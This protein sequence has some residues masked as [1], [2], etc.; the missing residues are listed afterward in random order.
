MDSRP[1]SFEWGASLPVQAAT[2]L[3]LAV[4]FAGFGIGGMWDVLSVFPEPVSPWWQL[5]TAVPASAL[6]LVKRRAP[7]AGLVAAAALFVAD[8]LTLGGITPMLVMLEFLHAVTIGLSPDRRKRVP[9]VLVAAVL[10]L[11]AAVLMRSGDLRLALLVGITFGALLGFS[12]WYANSVAQARELVELHRQR[13][14]DAGRLAEF[15]RTAAVQGERDRMAREL[16]DVVAGYISA[17]AIRSEASL[18]LPGEDSPERASLRAVRDASL[19][20]HETLRSMI[21]V[22]RS[23]ESEFSLSPGRDRI[24]E[25][26][27][28]ARASGVRASLEDG[29]AGEL[30]TPIDQAVGRIV[31]EALA[32]AVRHASGAEVAVRISETSGEVRVDV[33]SNGGSA[34]ASPALDGSGMGLEMIAERARALGG[35][36]TAGPEGDTAWTVRARLPKEAGR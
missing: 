6:M 16:H 11:A 35:E 13:A 15:D 22:L 36:L 32:N 10:P 17:V 27:E 29:L 12:Y 5:V 34:L 9:A 23:G 20:A 8:L 2:Y 1:L 30:S 24:P 25:L 18:N 3:L 33:V 4:V 14:E 21:R 19:E 26:V 28:T 7:R 31:Q